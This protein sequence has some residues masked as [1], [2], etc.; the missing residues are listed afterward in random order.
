MNEYVEVSTRMELVINELSCQL[1]KIQKNVTN[2]CIIEMPW[3]Q[4]VYII[5]LV[6]CTLQMSQNKRRVH[7]DN[8][9]GNS[10]PSMMTSRIINEPKTVKTG[11]PDTLFPFVC[12]M[13][14][15]RFSDKKVYSDH[16]EGH[17]R[18][19]CSFCG[20]PFKNRARLSN[21]EA[22]HKGLFKFRCR[23]CNKGFNHKNDY[24]K[25]EETHVSSKKIVHVID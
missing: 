15:T 10:S 4:L 12:N 7:I 22:Q 23:Y 6:L 9:A 3:L 14:Q 18:L 25:H 24:S 21:H 19:H 2:V 8:R 17:K 5:S 20:K 13:C 1:Q 11:I 16:M